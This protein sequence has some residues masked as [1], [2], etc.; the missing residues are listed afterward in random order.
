MVIWA[1]YFTTVHENRGSHIAGKKGKDRAD[2]A[3][4]RPITLLNTDYK[5]LTKTLSHRLKSVITSIVHPNQNGFVP[6]GS[7]FFSSHTIRDI[8]FYCKKEN[9]D[10][11]LLALDYTKAFDSVDFGFIFKTFETFGFGPK[12]Q[13]WIKTLYNLSLIH[14]WRCRRIERCRSRWSPYH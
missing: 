6:G 3:N 9:I 7:I 8:L 14:I 5:L 2:I 13:K 1:G 11:I 10:L 4:C 12:C